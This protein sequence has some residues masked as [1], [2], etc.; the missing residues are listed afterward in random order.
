M[1]SN[2]SERVM[3][4]LRKQKTRSFISFTCAQNSLN[5]CFVYTDGPRY[6]QFNGCA[7]NLLKITLSDGR[8][9]VT[10]DLWYEKYV[11]ECTLFGTVTTYINNEG[12]NESYVY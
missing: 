12:F 6:D 2:E 1:E 9:I 5:T 4:M 10:N 8:V 7:G 11:P 3:E